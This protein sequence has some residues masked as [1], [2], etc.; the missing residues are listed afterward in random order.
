[1]SELITQTEIQREKGF[2]YF[3]KSDEKGLLG[4]H[5]AI[6]GRKKVEKKAETLET[7]KK[8]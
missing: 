6:A 1:M 5:R 8:E 7:E 2:I 3:V 4:I